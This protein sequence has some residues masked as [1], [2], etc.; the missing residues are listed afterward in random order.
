MGIIKVSL[1]IINLKSNGIPFPFCLTLVAPRKTRRSLPLLTHLVL[2]CSHDEAFTKPTHNSGNCF[3]P[4]T[5]SISPSF[6]ISSTVS[7][8]ETPLPFHLLSFSCSHP[9]PT[10]SPSNLL[11]PS[12]AIKSTF[13]SV[14]RP[15]F[16]T[17]SFSYLNPVVPFPAL[18][19][20]SLLAD[21]CTSLPRSLSFPPSLHRGR[22]TTSMF[23]SDAVYLI[24][25]PQGISHMEPSLY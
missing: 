7:S 25:V 1:S 11:Y 4:L 13:Q 2:S 10:R 17:F 19:S 16:C 21:H 23:P 3:H 22:G 18:H 9:P 8:D 20:S 12:L 6:F 5:V 24:S 15:H 14:W